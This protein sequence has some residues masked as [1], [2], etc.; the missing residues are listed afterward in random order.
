VVSK[1]SAIN[2]NNNNI[3]CGLKAT[4]VT[5]ITTTTPVTTRSIIPLIDM[6]F[7]TL[8]TT[9]SNGGGTSFSDLYGYDNDGTYNYVIDHGLNKVFKFSSFWAYLSSTSLSISLP[10]YLKYVSGYWYI[11]GNNGIY[12]TDST[13]TTIVA[14][15][16]TGPHYGLYYY[17]T[18]STIYAVKSTSI[19]EYT[20]N[21]ALSYTNNIS[22]YILWSIT[23]TGTTFYIGTTTG[24]ILVIVNR[25]IT[26]TFTAACSGPVNS[27]VI[28]GTALLTECNGDSYFNTGSGSSFTYVSVIGGPGFTAKGIWIDLR[29]QLIRTDESSFLIYN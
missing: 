9:I 7:Y 4:S 1:S 21:L 18:T 16:T 3:I 28:Q 6:R 2:T 24:T 13:F 26:G 25:L 22:G 10:N 19:I 14:Y 17:S 11:T 12:K 20:T 8:N 27:I 5:T 29:N 23:A 15:V